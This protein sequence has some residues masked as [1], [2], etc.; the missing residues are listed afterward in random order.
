[1]NIACFKTVR[2]RRDN[3]DKYND[4][5]TGIKKKKINKG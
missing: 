3:L 1:M 5:K 4:K 2:F